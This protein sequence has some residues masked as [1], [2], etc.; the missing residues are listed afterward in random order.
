MWRRGRDWHGF[1]ADAFLK[2]RDRRLELRIVPIEG[3]MRQVVHQDIRV[4]AM[5]FNEPFA[6]RAVNAVLGG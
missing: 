2:M 5:S 4:D 1:E 6:F 3:C